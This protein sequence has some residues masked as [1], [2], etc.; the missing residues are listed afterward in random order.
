MGRGKPARP[1]V[2]RPDALALYDPSSTT[3]VE[4]VKAAAKAQGCTCEPT[5]TLSDVR[6]LVQHD[7]WCVLLRRK[8][9]N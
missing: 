2:A 1:R 6:A 5:V 9:T 8:D 4:A 3:A 7:E